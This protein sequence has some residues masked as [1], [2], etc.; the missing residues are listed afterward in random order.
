[1]PI[2]KGDSL[3]GCSPM[4]PY[5]SDHTEDRQSSRAGAIWNPD[6]SISVDTSGRGLKLAL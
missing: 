6:H 5:V 1:L 4:K 3:S 2:R